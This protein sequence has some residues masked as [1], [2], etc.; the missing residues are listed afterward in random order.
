MGDQTLDGLQVRAAPV[1]EVREDDD[2]GY[3]E[4][5]IVPYEV[6]TQLAERYFEVFSRGAFSGAIGNPGRCI[7][8]N[9]QH[10]MGNPIGRAIELRDEQDGHY[11]VIRIPKTSR[12]LD[13]LKLC[14]GEVLTEIS[15][16]FMPQKRNRREEWRDGDL[17]IRHDRATLTGCSPVTA[18]AYGEHAR[19]IAVRDRV[20]KIREREVAF[21]ESLRAGAKQA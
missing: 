7:M 14:R 19:V 10:D 21:L 16:E 8:S 1:L 13:V 20:E 9:A 11:G 3:L 15:A 5:K 17:H 12:G 2:Y 4:V 18:G 6:E